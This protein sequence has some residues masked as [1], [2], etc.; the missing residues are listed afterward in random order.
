MT[1]AEVVSEIRRVFDRDP[2]KELAGLADRLRRAG[3]DEAF[4]ALFPIASRGQSL[5]PAA[6]AAWLLLRV[7]P[8][9]PISC[10][11]ATR[12]L[13]TDWDVSIEEVPFYLAEQFGSA[14]VREAVVVLRRT[15]SAEKQLQTLSTIEYWL[16][17]SDEMQASKTKERNAEPSAPP[18]G[19]SSTVK[20][21]GSLVIN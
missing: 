21:D 8:R 10:L 14:L 9:C 18:H 16:G 4:H 3:G 11:E 7:N 5:G 13:L 2:E 20:S 6:G 1:P 19:P 17:C 15:I 12:E